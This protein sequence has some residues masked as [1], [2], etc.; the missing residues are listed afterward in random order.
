M[1][2]QIK[3]PKRPE[4]ARTHT[5]SPLFIDDA[6][7]KAAMQRVGAKYDKA[8]AEVQR[9]PAMMAEVHALLAETPSDND[10]AVFIPWMR[11]GAVMPF[12]DF[13]TELLEIQFTPAQRTLSR[14]VF[15]NVDPIDI[16]DPEERRI[17][18]DMFG[19]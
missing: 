9:S 10:D 3:Q 11:D 6:E 7:M 4:K 15:D 19:G 16:T 8:L 17:A 13:A 1:A 18:V 12:V 2:R 5:R 14:V